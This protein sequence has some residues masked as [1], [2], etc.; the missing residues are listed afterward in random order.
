MRRNIVEQFIKMLLPALAAILAIICMLDTFGWFSKSRSVTGNGM[1]VSTND[2]GLLEIRANA[3]G[4]DISAFVVDDITERLTNQTNQNNLLPTASGSFTFYVCDSSSEALTP[5]DFIYRLSIE[6]DPHKENNGFYADTNEGEQKQALQY[7]NSHLLFF[8]EYD[9]GTK[10]YKGWLQ[11]GE[12]IRCTADQNPK[13]VTVYWVWVD[14]YK[15]IFEES[16]GLFD[17]ETRA[18]IAEFYENNTEM[19][20]VGDAPSAEAYNMADTLIGMTLKYV[21]F[22]IEVIK[23]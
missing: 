21:C 15:Q 7:I 16:S 23:V 3:T 12:P 6:N 19:M 20:L 14:Q 17:N 22:L 11:S 10:V 5:Y 4:P 18:K 8:S 1:N 9:E 2:V 13:A